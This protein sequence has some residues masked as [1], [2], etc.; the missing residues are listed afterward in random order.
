MTLL[1]PLGLLGLLSV[2]ALIVIYVVKPNYQHKEVTSTYVWKLSMKY[3]KRRLPTSKLRNILLIVCQ[4][5][6]LIAG[7]LIMSQ[8]IIRDAKGVFDT[9]VVAIIDASA[10]MRTQDGNGVTRFEKAVEQA[11]ELLNDTIDKGGYASVILSG[12]DEGF[13]VQ[14]TGI[15]GRA[16]LNAKLK[17]LID[18]RDAL[19]C[20]Y[21]TASLDDS[22]T[23]CEDVIRN[24]PTAS[25]YVYTDADYVS[26][27]KEITL[28]NVAEESEWNVGI[29]NAYTQFEEGYYTFFVEVGCY[30][31]VSRKVNLEVS[32]NAANASSTKPEGEFIRYSADVTLRD[33]SVTTV[34]FRNSDITIADY[35][36]AAENLVIVPVGSSVIGQNNKTCVF[37]YNDAHITVNENDSLQLDNNFS[38]YGGKKKPLR[39]QYATYKQRTFYTAMFGVLRK[40]YADYWELDVDE[41]NLSDP[42]A[43]C[44]TMGYDLYIFEG[45]TPLQMPHDGVVYLANPET[46][47]AGLT[48]RDVVT[49]GQEMYFVKEGDHPVIKNTDAAKIYAR[50]LTRLS[51]YDE[52]VY[53]PLWSAESNP[54]LLIN[55]GEGEKVIVSLFDIEWSNF[56]LRNDFSFFIYNIFETFL[57]ATVRGNAFEVG[58]EITVNARG[59]SLKISRNSGSEEKTVTDFP[60]SI[61]LDAPDTYRF[62]QVNYFGDNEP[63]DYIYVKVPA[64]ESNISATGISLKA[65]YREKVDETAYQ[66]LLVYLAAAMLALLF[67]EWFLQTQESL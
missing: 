9:E 60:S 45:Y 42:K 65:L 28:V 51:Q 21:G 52:T 34:I 27:P 19:G 26:K 11:T 53:K 5:L 35:E 64:A 50:K 18:D 24:N 59:N 13:L 54:V 8:P 44:K 33:N 17:A 41:V 61:R 25:V 39:I 14:K 31:G 22:I 20:S 10:S 49:Y 23:L 56:G 55:D 67:T 30:G 15:A 16:D 66:D 12:G 57:P 36:A 46:L 3:R 40:H 47:P 43:E 38:L 63:D 32:I 2:I 4:V 7:A 48:A 58:Q 62:S 37:S 29:L 6:A 1:I